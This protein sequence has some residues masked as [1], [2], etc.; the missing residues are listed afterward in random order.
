[1]VKK[2]FRYFLL[3][4]LFLL[5]TCDRYEFPP[6]VYPAIE[7]L[8][9]EDISESG[10]TFRANLSRL[11]STTITSHGF[12][13]GFNQGLQNAEKIDFGIA[14]ETGVIEAVLDEGLHADTT[15]FLKAFAATET[16]VV[17]GEVKWFEVE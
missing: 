2:A 16:Y 10:V 15:Y 3:A 13:Y 9:P 1:M 6:S 12:L 4:G 11:G 5:Q 17:Y 7:T 8:D 14:S